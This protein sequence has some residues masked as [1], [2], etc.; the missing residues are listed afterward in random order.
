MHEAAISSI[1]IR[2]ENPW[3]WSSVNPRSG[4]DL[5]AKADS[6]KTKPL[7]R[8]RGRLSFQVQVRMLPLLRSAALAHLTAPPPTS[9]HPPTDASVHGPPWPARQ[10]RP[11]GRPTAVPRPVTADA[12]R[13]RWPLLP[14]IVCAWAP[15]APRRARD[16]RGGVSGSPSILLRPVPLVLP[17]D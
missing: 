2:K 16:G 6:A 12:T 3:M 15:A 5:T 13:T 14:G 11:L 4:R 7:G 17:R 1:F 10:W 8:I 9:S